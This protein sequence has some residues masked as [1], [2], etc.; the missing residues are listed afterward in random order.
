M[1]AGFV[2]DFS[3]LFKP[4]AAFQT[5]IAATPEAHHAYW[6][7]LLVGNQ[8]DVIVAAAATAVGI[9]MTFL[10]PY[11]ILRRGWGREFAGLMR[12][13]L[14]TGMLIPFTLATSFVVI[15]AAS[16][17][18]AVAEPGILPDADVVA[19]SP[20]AV[21]ADASPNQRREYAN[22]LQGLGS[23]ET[24]TREDRQ[25]AAMLVTRDAFQLATALEPLTGVFFG[26][27]LFS[28]GVLGMTLSS[29]TL[30]M[31]ITGM[32]TC[33]LANR[34]HAG[35]TFRLGSLLPVT[36]V[37]G[38]F[39]WSKASF[40]LAVPTSIFGFILMPIAY[41]TFFLL[42]NQRRLLG[43]AMPTGGRRV[44]W[45]GLMGTCL[46]I[47]GAAS[48]YMLWDKGGIWGLAAAGT[49]LA[50]ALV[51]DLRRRSRSNNSR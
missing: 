14:A 8:R 15:A 2:P 47:S 6:T 49:F 17:F 21:G 22:L 7:A 31:L 51:V 50:A 19:A 20:A 46:L 28:V 25:L 34:P 37:L 42:M 40:W 4:A 43:D 29:I 35:W 11:S 26:R 36:G 44:V 3:L 23:D 30:L 10:F 24:V 16:Q 5:V 18:H 33:E 41:L 27:V 1:V 13:D 38:P 32:I 48:A 12:F 39:L 45:N 9:N